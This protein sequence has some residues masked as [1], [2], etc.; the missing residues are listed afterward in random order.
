MASEP[1]VE[2]ELQLA[3]RLG[4]LRYRQFCATRVRC[5][6]DEGLAL[7]EKIAGARSTRGA[8][9]LIEAGLAIE[10]AQIGAD[11]VV[12]QRDRA[13]RVLV[14]ELVQLGVDL[15]PLLQNA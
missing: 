2:S 4:L 15:A 9:E 12:E 3:I 10:R 1:L 13:A 5:L 8:V 11:E 14:S 6:A 7:H